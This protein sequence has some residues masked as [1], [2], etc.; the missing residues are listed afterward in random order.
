MD[1]AQCDMLRRFGNSPMSIE[2]VDS[3]HGT[4]G[5]DF[6]LSKVM[7]LDDNRQSFPMV[8]LY[9][10]RETED[11]FQLFFQAIKVKA[12]DITCNTFTS[13]MT[14]QFYNAKQTVMGVAQQWQNNVT[15]HTL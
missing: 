11:I 5:Y 14:P 2:C 12:G 10:N 6:H 9:S 8:F 3:T 7:V 13:D 4:D 1:E 15:D